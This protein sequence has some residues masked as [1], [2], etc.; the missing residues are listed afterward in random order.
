MAVLTLPV[1]PFS[2]KWKGHLVLI[3]FFIY[4]PQNKK[5]V[6]KSYISK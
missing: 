1:F 4:S 6:S 2:T 3:P 5:I